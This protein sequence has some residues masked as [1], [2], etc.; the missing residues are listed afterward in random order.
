MWALFWSPQAGQSLYQ[1]GQTKGDEHTSPSQRAKH[2]R[3]YLGNQAGSSCFYYY[4]G[5]QAASVKKMPGPE[6][7][8]RGAASCCYVKETRKLAGRLKQV[9]EQ[10]LPG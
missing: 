2:N 3:L 7:W 9:T 1:W 8:G 5:H 4:F 10:G 6:T